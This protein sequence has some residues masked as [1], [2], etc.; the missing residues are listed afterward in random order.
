MNN[1]YKNG[2]IYCIWSYETDDIYIGSSYNELDHRLRQHKD[3]YKKFLNGKGKYYSSFEIIK[4]GDAEIGIIEEFSCQFRKELTRREGKLQR[5]IKCVNKNIAGRTQ[6]EYEEDNKEQLEEYRKIY[7]EKNKEPIAKKKKEYYENNKEPIA[8]KGKIYRE[9]NKESLIKRNKK[10]NEKNKEPI[11]KKR[12]IRYE[13]N[14]EEIAEKR[15]KKFICE[16]GSNIRISDKAIHCRSIKHQKYLEQQQQ[17][18]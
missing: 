8:K 5:E 6:K 9:K 4:Y 1:K 11:A 17:E 7:R 18:L 3:N 15:K 16:C 13:K 10:Y 2:K 12:K 14:K